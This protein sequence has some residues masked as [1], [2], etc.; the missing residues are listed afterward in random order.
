M[1]TQAL[2]DRVFQR[3][4]APSSVSSYQIHHWPQSGKPTEEAVGVLPVPGVD[5]EKLIARVMDVDNY[6]GNVPHVIESRSIQDPRFDGKSQIRFYQRVKIPVLGAIH[7]ELVLKDGGE[8]QGYR[9]AYWDFLEKE[10]NAL[11]SKKAARSQ[12]NQ[13]AWLVGDG[14]VAYALSSAPRRDDVGRLKFAAL[15]KG[16][17]VAAAKVLRDNIEGMAAWSRRG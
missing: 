8:R 4:P 2:L 15:T 9:I 11:S 13:G 5:A 1:D 10:T 7:Y 16:A 12:Y 3:V 14:V 6:V 17:D